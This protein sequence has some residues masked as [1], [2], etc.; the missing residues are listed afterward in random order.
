MKSRFYGKLTYLKILLA[1]SDF[2][3]TAG[4]IDRIL[5]KEQLLS[6]CIKILY[7]IRETD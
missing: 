4:T 6:K 7:I 5:L 3:I 2:D 1:R